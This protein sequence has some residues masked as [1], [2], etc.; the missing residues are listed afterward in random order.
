MLSSSFAKFSM[1]NEPP[2]EGGIVG[3]RVSVKKIPLRRTSLLAQN[4]STPPPREGTSSGTGRIEESNE[5]GA[6]S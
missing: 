2:I 4:V 5:E 3:S 1:N 6:E